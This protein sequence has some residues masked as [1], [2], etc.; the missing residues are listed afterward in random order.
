MCRA[1]SA[2]AGRSSPNLSVWSPQSA[3]VWLA[4]AFFSCLSMSIAGIVLKRDRLMGI[5]QAITMPL[6][7]AS[8]AL[9]PVAL[10]PDWLRVISH[11]NPLSYEVDALRGLLLGAPAHVA[12]DFAVLAVAAL[13]SIGVAGRLLERLAR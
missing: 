13:L 3:A 7:F 9:Y 8:N 5:G 1:T 12:A 2:P 10:M 11:V 4:A 6:F